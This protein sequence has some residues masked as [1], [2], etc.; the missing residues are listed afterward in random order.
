MK[1]PWDEEL[2]EFLQ[3]RMAPWIPSLCSSKES[4]LR[5]IDGGATPTVAVAEADRLFTKF[6]VTILK[7]PILLPSENFLGDK[8]TGAVTGEDDGVK[9]SDDFTLFETFE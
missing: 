6:R 2:K 3:W 4:S 9:E 1:V 7:L 5:R 8:F